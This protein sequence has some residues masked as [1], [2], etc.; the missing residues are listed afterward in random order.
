MSAHIIG[1][2]LIIAVL[3]MLYCI[4][5]ISRRINTNVAG[6]QWRMASYDN[7]TEAAN[8]LANTHNK[9]VNLLRHLKKKYRID[10]PGYVPEG[11]IL[12]H[13]SL[14][15][16]LDNYNPDVLYENDPAKSSA[17]S[18]TN[19]KGES[20]F[21]CVRDRTRPTKLVDPDILLFVMLHEISHIANVRSWGHDDTFWET[22]LFILHEAELIGIYKPVDYS[23]K[24]IMYCGL[25]VDYNPM[26]DA[27]VRKIWE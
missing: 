27:S 9:I 4:A 11:N 25:N 2:I 21:I 26:F 5:R 6:R 17:T 8:L 24:P 7:R 15:A 12:I 16:L 20:M 22:F 19:N 18:Y 1:A 3:I 13:K 10:E 14:D 23:K